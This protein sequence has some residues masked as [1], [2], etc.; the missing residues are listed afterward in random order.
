M[1]QIFFQTLLFFGFFLAASA[2]VTF[3][4]RHM[5]LRPFDEFQRIWRGRIQKSAGAPG[6]INQHN[7]YI[8]LQVKVNDV[9]EQE[10]CV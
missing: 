2:G 1:G 9:D 3:R 10:S 6:N 7:M 8:N 4:F 5:V